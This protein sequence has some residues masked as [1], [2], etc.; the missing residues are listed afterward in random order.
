MLATHSLTSSL[1]L[2]NYVAI[3]VLAFCCGASQVAHASCGDYLMPLGTHHADSSVKGASLA[4]HPSASSLLLLAVE[5]SS[6]PCHGPG[7][8]QSK[9]A[10][11]FTTSVVPVNRNVQLD[12][13]SG[14][15]ARNLPDALKVEWFVIT[16]D[17][18]T[19]HC[20]GSLFRPPRQIAG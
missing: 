14:E 10:E 8:G 16:S 13:C 5:P 1:R 12:L 7:C 3:A 6:Q 9:P 17:T 15:P 19:T 11:G 20:L 4:L 18:I 2:R